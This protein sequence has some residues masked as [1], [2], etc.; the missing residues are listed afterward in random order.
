M[1][2]KELSHGLTKLEGERWTD[3]AETIHNCR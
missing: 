2:L 3:V 1:L